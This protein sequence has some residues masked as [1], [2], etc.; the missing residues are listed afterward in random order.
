[1][2]LSQAALDLTKRFRD[3]WVNAV[4]DVYGAP[5]GMGRKKLM[6]WDKKRADEL[7]RAP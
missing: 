2:Y 6:A 1:M 7:V 3:G 4:N 5:F